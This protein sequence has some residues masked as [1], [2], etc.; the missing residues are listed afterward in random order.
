MKM[1]SIDPKD[2][3][4]DIYK[5]EN[6]DIIMEELKIN[7]IHSFNL[8]IETLRKHK[9]LVFSKLRNLLLDDKI[10]YYQDII[11][12]LEGYDKILYEF[13]IEK[14]KELIELTILFKKGDDFFEGGYKLKRTDIK[15]KFHFNNNNY[16]RCILIDNKNKKY[17]KI[18]GEIVDLQKIK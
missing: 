12:K 7:N 1:G 18:N 8:I 11:E 17:V 13:S 14:L 9:T 6:L 4:I 2:E 5:N 10:R 16:T 15:I 3:C